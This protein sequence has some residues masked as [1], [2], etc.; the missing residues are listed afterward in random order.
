MV[1]MSL[2]VGVVRFPCGEAVERL[3]AYPTSTVA[4]VGEV[5][6]DA[7]Y[8]PGKDGHVAY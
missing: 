1:G 4:V 6:V 2:G 7:G 5:R 3:A 8:R